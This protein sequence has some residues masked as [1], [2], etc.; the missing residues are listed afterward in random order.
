MQSP[1][2]QLLQS[3]QVSPQTRRIL[4]E[5]IALPGYKPGFFTAEEWPLVEAFSEAVLPQ[6]HP[7]T[8]APCAALIDQ[9]LT[10]EEGSGWRYAALPPAPIA[11]RLALQ[12]IREALTQADAPTIAILLNQIQHKQHDTPT[13]PISLWLEGF[14]VDVVRYW[15][16]H[17]DT[18]VALDYRGFADDRLTPHDALT[19]IQVIKQ[20]QR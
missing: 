13:F 7:F 16:A 4:E 12:I 20:A 3:D 11:Y 6:T 2:I 1:F 9:A 14:K 17:P 10:R 5:R 8:N 19:E 18:M 15:L